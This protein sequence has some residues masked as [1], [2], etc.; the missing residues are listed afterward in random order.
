M[1]RKFALAWPSLAIVAGA[2]GIIVIAPFAGNRVSTLLI[3]GVITLGIIAASSRSLPFAAMS[4]LLVTFLFPPWIY[5]MVGGTRLAPAA[6]ISLIVIVARIG[7]TRLRVNIVDLLAVALVLV[8]LLGSVFSSTPPHV[9]SQV[10][11]EWGLPYLAARVLSSDTNLISRL[12]TMGLVLGL[13]AVAQSATRIDLS[14]FPP[15]S[16]SVGATNWMGLQGRAGLVRAELTT[17]QS[18]ALGG[19]LVLLL[20]FAL[21]AESKA[22]RVLGSIAI[23]AGILATISRA[24]LVSGII[25]IFLCL[26]FSA[27]SKATKSILLVITM[28]AAVSAAT[29][30]GDFLERSSGTNELN[31]STSYRGG[32]LGL[33]RYVQPLGLASSG[34]PSGGGATFL[35]DGYYSIDNGVL[36]IA[37]Y[38]GGIASILFVLVTVVFA[39]RLV[40]GNVDS[41]SIAIVAQLPLL[42]SV[43]P[44]TQYQNF[45]W[46]FI[47]LAASWSFNKIGTL[48]K[49][50]R[51]AVPAFSGLS[52]PLPGRMISSSKQHPIS[53]NGS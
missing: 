21:R 30:F 10:V 24:A 1:N 26:W 41:A 36:Y 6:I 4:W 20:P 29:F 7:K 8:G 38:V 14:T 51:D 23:M 25:A 5:L 33:L 48:A 11:L 3:V 39:L 35:W 32:L 53:R 40:R 15:F 16:F 43:A 22:L 42:F 37:L 47:G 27:I 31:D 49:E 45:L 46:F 50:E 52:S 34:V 18:I 44:I 28:T 19:I 12:P 13:L 17:G 9:L 2:V